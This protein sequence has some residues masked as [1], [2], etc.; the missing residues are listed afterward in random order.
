MVGAG[1]PA[2]SGGESVVFH[3]LGGREAAA[4]RVRVVVNPDAVRPP[5]KA[6][7]DA[8]NPP[9]VLTG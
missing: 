6:G 2:S 9:T 7:Q 5:A 3:Q 4:L 1:G 8:L